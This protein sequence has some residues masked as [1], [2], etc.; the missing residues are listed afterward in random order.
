MDQFPAAVEVLVGGGGTTFR[1]RFADPVAVRALIVYVGNGLV[2]IGIVFLLYQ[3]Q[4]R[5][6]LLS[7]QSKCYV[8][9]VQL[10]HAKSPLSIEMQ[11]LLAAAVAIIAHHQV[12][13]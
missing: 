10:A 3:A 7:L 2:R 12:L 1:H 8:F 13:F 9:N 4:A 6:H 5:H 11:F